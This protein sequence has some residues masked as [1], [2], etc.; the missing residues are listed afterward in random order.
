MSLI[1]S[2]IA[3]ELPQELQMGRSGQH[4]HHVEIPGSN[5]GRSHQQANA[6]NRKGSTEHS[7]F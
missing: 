1:R 6:D 5:I 7:A 4:P 2:F 3:V